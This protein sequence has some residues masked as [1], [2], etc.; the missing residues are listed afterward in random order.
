MDRKSPFQFGCSSSTPRLLRLLRQHAL[1]CAP[2]FS[3]IMGPGLRQD[4]LWPCNDLQLRWCRSR[5]EM[6]LERRIWGGGKDS[7]TK[8]D[9]WKNFYVHTDVSC[10]TELH[11]RAER[12]HFPKA[13]VHQLE[14]ARVDGTSQGFA[15]AAFE[16][17]HWKLC[18]QP[19]LPAL[20]LIS[21]LFSA[22]WRIFHKTEAW[23]NSKDVTYCMLKDEACWYCTC[24]YSKLV[25]KQIKSK[26]VM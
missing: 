16:E 23:A 26:W 15:A 10:W 17:S 5:R 24:I 20:I 9:L 6:E 3:S 19:C 22:E 4:A 11:L 7:R 8:H 25:L 14:K 18:F 12:S 21:A 13:G 1:K 2:L